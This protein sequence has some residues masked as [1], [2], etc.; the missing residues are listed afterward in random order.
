MSGVADLG[1]SIWCNYIR[2]SFL[3][4]GELQTLID[5]GLRGITSRPSFFEKVIAGSADY[6]DELKLL[7]E[8]NRPPEDIYETLML[9]DFSK[10]ADL[11]RPVYETTEGRDGYVSL[12]VSPRSANNTVASISEAK[13][14]FEAFNLPNI[15]IEIPATPAGIPAITDL[16]GSGV[17]VNVGLI[18]S[19]ENYR[20]VAEAYLL[21]L[22]KLA[23]NGP[24][25]VCG[26]D[27][28]SVASVASFS[29]NRIDSAVDFELKKI[30]NSQLQGKIAIANAKA[31]YIAFRDIF[32]GRR[33]EDLSEKG[34]RVQRLSWVG[35]GTKNPLYPDILYV[36]ELIGPDTVSAVPPATLCAFLDHGAVDLTLTKGLEKAR[37]L[38]TQLSTLGIDLSAIANRLQADGVNESARS[39]ESV[40]AGI[41]EKGA[42]LAA[43]KGDLTAYLHDFQLLVEDELVHLRNDSVMNRIWAHDH[44]VWKDDPA[45]ISNR[46]GWLHS[47]DIM[48]DAIP[49]ITALVKEVRA[50]G[51][52]YALLLGMGGSSLAP[53]MYRM[54][55]GVKDG[56]LDLAVLDSTD[57][58]AVLE[59][60]RNI[61]IEK[62]L[63]IVSSKSGGTV[64]THSFMNY[65]FNWVADSVGLENAGRHFVAIT[66][67]GSGLESTA[68]ELR[69]RKIFLNDPNIG[70][71]YSA[72]SYFG[73]VPA[74]LI[75][76]DLAILLERAAI[77][78][79]NSEGCNCP[80]ADDNNAAWLGAAMGKLSDL[81]RDKLTLVV[82]PSI[83]HF[84]IWVEQLIAEST[85]KDGKGILPVTGEM[86]ASPD[87]YSNDRLF[88]H[89]RLANDN[90]Y[91]KKVKALIEARHPVIQI[92]LRDLYDL[93]G[94][95]FLWEMATAV[96]GSVLGINPFDQPNVESAKVLA[97][98]MVA[99]YQKQGKLP[100][101]TPTFCTDGVSV[102][103][104]LSCR[105]LKEAIQEFLAQANPGK[106]DSMGRSYIAIQAYIK[107]TMETDT[108][109]QELR[110]ELQLRYRMATT[111]G[112]GPRFLHSTGQ[113]HKGDK[114]HGLFIQVTVDMWEDTPIPD[115]AGSNGSS[116]GFGVLK[117]AQAVGDCEALLDAGRKVIRFHFPDAVGGLRELKEAVGG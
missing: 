33:W 43:N 55:F 90:S 107:P 73:L 14:L 112:Y 34:A 58:G 71:R 13:R 49:E 70:G 6:D 63:F 81:G 4:S 7:I 109:L 67:P 91:D 11:L 89:L 72:L 47:P 19:V 108:A 20:A 29:V 22:E 42:Y 17:N 79:C 39:F 87:K 45:E 103:S 37:L 21:G 38:L 32:R 92:N 94:E 86:V 25:V 104:D 56:Y 111:V 23:A 85:G 60:A 57:P 99:T 9:Q 5:R 96:A 41:S 75:G 88:V 102:Y 114:G 26:H 115:Q 2:R 51:Y 36:E 53:E 35:T 95:C 97:R 80:A 84:G 16:I 98:Q 106:D 64:E 65:F 61:D 1:Q 93:G 15:M 18:L 68:R 83:S 3:F 52:T 78:A 76:V 10:A 46:L 62:T 30:G 28:S 77:M 66:D 100:A 74:A 101:S 48:T 69:F 82:S 54:V 50:A 31:A 113:L 105:N 27:V 44:T 24:T 8:E 40:M 116:I 59:Y 117:I 12:E 110:T